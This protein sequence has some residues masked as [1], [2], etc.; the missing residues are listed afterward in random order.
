M[1]QD[2]AGATR[3]VHTAQKKGIPVFDTMAGLG[4]WLKSKSKSQQRRLA[5]Q[6]GIEE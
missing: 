4:A 1:W 5:I 3:E 2:S 6:G